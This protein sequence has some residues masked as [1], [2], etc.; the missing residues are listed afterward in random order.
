LK[1]A[2]IFADYDG[3]IAPEDVP[4][5]SSRVP[6]AIEGP[7]RALSSSLPVA[8]VTSK[9]CG[10][11]RPRTKFADAWACVSG[12]EIVLSDGRSFATPG[13]GARLREGLSYVRS[14]DGLGLKLELKRST[15]GDLLGFSVDWRNA[16]N[17]PSG[18][19]GT[20]TA[21]L[22][23]MDL[24]VVHDQ[25]RPFFDVFGG[26]PDKGRAVR[27]LK[28]LLKVAGKV[29][30]VGDSIVDNS[31]FEEAD[32]AI[33][34]DHGQSFEGIACRF[35]IRQERLGPFL[36]SLVGGRLSLNLLD[37]MQK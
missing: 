1:I 25:N 20:A 29:M 14:H 13:G 26:R 16:P 24:W 9:D 34:V 11:V 21:E 17:P 30:F 2:A 27:E 7:L 36:R 19:I 32:V 22:T 28:R 6:K 8:I 12:L 31:A 3:T 35:A 37:P 15:T 33:G 4:L 10:F 18:F 23:R 5:E